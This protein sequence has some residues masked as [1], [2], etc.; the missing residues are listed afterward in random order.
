LVPAVLLLQVQMVLELMETIAFFQ[1]SLLPVEVE[2]EEG[3]AETL[4]E[5]LLVVLEVEHLLELVV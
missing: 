2:A 4:Q 5:E 3:L 1:Q